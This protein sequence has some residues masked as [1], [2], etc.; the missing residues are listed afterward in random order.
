MLGL[1]WDLWWAQ[2]GPH[3]H[4][5]VG[6]P[7]GFG[8]IN[9]TM[10]LRGSTSWVHWVFLETKHGL[11]WDHIF[12]GTLFRGNTSRVWLHFFD[13]AR[14]V[15]ERYVDSFCTWEQQGKMARLKWD[16]VWVFLGRVQVSWKPHYRLMLWDWWGA[17][18]F[19]FLWLVNRVSPAELFFFRNCSDLRG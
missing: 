9:E 4:G 8:L 16:Q 7:G 10:V 18:F 13:G 3:F 15:C 12:W 6:T 19:D 1:R 2:M 17:W 11:K 14:F 5:L